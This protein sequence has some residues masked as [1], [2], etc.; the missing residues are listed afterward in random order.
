ME[1]KYKQNKVKKKKKTKIGI[2][3]LTL[4]DARR[5]GDLPARR[6]RDTERREQKCRAKLAYRVY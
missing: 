5:N 6:G 2:V 4:V 3:G 1:K